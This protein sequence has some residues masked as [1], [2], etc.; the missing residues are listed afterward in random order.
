MKRAV[1]IIFG[2]SKG[3]SG[4][5]QTK[6]KKTT[7]K[8]IKKIVNES[9]DEGGEEGDFP[10]PLPNFF[11]QEEDELIYLNQNHL[12]FHTEVSEQSV[13]KVKNLM[14]EYLNKVT[15][16]K[17]THIMGV[18]TPKPLYLHIYSPGG[19]VHAGFSLYDFIIS[20]DKH[21]PVHT[22]IEGSAASAATMISIAGSKRYIT[23]S[24]YMLIHQLS[25]FFGGNFEQIKDEF[26]NCQKLMTRI[27][28]IYS[29]KTT[30]PKKQLDD[31]LKHD[32]F[33]DANECLKYGLVDEIKLIDLFNDDLNL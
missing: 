6:K 29:D 15:K 31:I 28:K 9:D 5:S 3:G 14:R 12:F 8:P 2:D 25:T 33:W 18:F 16:V 22:I 26:S 30:I 32:I 24:S 13:D 23:P 27:K 19:D 1:S 20:Y 10:F 11:K 21:I 4:D 7:K 17:K